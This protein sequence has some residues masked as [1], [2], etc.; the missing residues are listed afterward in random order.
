MEKSKFSFGRSV[1][2]FSKPIIATFLLFCSYYGYTQT[3]GA[4]ACNDLVQVSLDENCEADII[5][6]MIL[7]GT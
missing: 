2:R 7:E 6:D 1:L 3:G 5:P 4:L